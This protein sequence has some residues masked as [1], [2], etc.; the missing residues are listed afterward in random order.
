MI[1]DERLR[2]AA[3]EAEEKLL[4]SL[5][6]PEDCEA[7]FSPEYKRKMKKLA[8]RTDHP[9]IYWVQKAVACILLTILIGGGGILTFSTEARAAFV[10]WVREVYE[11]WF[12]YQ[13]TGND[14]E[15]AEGVVYAPTWVPNG[16]ELTTSPEAGT[17]S[18]AIY[19]N[20]EGS[21]L[22]FNCSMN[23]E[24][25]NFRI[26]HK[27]TQLL[28]VYV[29]DIPADLYVDS[30]SGNTNYLIW[31]DENRQM[32]FWIISILDGET[33]IEIAES[34]KIVDE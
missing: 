16:Y 34:V 33:M 7:T 4:A 2:E 17:H 32:I 13:Y 12:V 20:S 28:H 8:R 18:T 15:P 14:Q 25:I 23:S 26:E 10:G 11:N 31:E 5:P 19:E 29:G 1:S 21:I 24:S 9:I 6:K 22:V 3:R 27:N 30:T